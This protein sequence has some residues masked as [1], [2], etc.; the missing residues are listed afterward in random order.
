M[1]LGR[2]TDTIRVSGSANLNMYLSIS[3]IPSLKV[4]LT[5]LV[6]YCQGMLW[7]LSL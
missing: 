3:P 1:V 4:S 7:K 2:L 6:A 5:F